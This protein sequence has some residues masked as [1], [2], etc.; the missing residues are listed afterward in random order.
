M[1]AVPGRVIPDDDVVNL[2]FVLLS[3]ETF[4]A[5]AGAEREPV[6]AVSVVT[7]LMRLVLGG[8]PA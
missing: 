8:V 6:D 5:F 2:P 4:D 7:P 1:G 3:F